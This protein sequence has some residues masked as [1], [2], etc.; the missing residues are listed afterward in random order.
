MTGDDGSEK[1]ESSSKNN[2]TSS[3]TTTT[4][5]QRRGAQPPKKDKKKDKQEKINQKT[6]T[7]IK[8]KSSHPTTPDLLNN[9]IPPSITIKKPARNRKLISDFLKN[10]LT[11]IV[12]EELEKRALAS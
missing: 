5:R 2:K 3:K 7:S 9:I 12:R 4:R 11:S 8:T 6:S 1:K 10:I